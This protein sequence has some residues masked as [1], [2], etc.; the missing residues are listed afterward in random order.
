M[1]VSSNEEFQCVAGTQLGVQVENLRLAGVHAPC[2][3]CLRPST[4]DG[5]AADSILLCNQENQYLSMEEKNP[6]CCLRTETWRRQRDLN[7]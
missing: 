7:Q 1:H 6:A 4:P 5:V 2:C 3:Y